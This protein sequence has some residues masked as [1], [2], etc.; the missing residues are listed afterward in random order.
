MWVSS[1]NVCKHEC[2]SL[3]GTPKNENWQN[4]SHAVN[5]DFLKDLVYSQK[6]F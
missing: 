6:T 3:L 1:V 2:A 5:P 4:I